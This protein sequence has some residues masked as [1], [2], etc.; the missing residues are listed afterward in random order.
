MQNN[1]TSANR[2]A[3]IW[4]LNA[5]QV[6]DGGDDDKKQVI[7]SSIKGNT[8]FLNEKNQIEMSMMRAVMLLN[9]SCC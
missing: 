4:L 2:M 5:P 1:D 9:L 8:Y 7:Y 3:A 6:E